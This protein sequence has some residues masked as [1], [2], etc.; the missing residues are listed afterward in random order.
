MVENSEVEFRV[1]AENAAGLGEASEPSLY[2]RIVD[3]IY[4]PGPPTYP[5]VTST[6]RSSVT[7][8]WRKPTYDG[9]Q[10]ISRYL[11]EYV[12]LRTGREYIPEEDVWIKCN[13]PV[14]F[15]DH[16]FVIKGLSENSEY[17]IR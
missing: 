10:E 1:I 13:M 7:V 9:G 6:T 3:P 4:P 2:V 8:I 14:D 12:K 11:V 17:K 5:A 15:K 16:E